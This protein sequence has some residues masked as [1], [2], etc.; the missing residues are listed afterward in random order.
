MSAFYTLATIEEAGY[1]SVDRQRG[2][3]GRGEETCT[4][5]KSGV[6]VAQADAQ[7]HKIDTQDSG[8]VRQDILR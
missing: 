2:S 4:T 7:T 8:L 1:L 6:G 3:Y 5:A